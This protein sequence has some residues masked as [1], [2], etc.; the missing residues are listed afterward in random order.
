MTGIT[1]AAVKSLRERTGAGMM[2]CKKALQETGGDEEKA[3]DLLRQK[4][5]AKAAKRSGKE[6]SEGTVFI[7]ANDGRAAMVELLS[8]T[9]FVARSDDFKGFARR[10][11][12]AIA[13]LD[14]PDGEI[15]SGDDLFQGDHVIVPVNQRFVAHVDRND[16]LLKATR[17][18]D[19]PFDLCAV[20]YSIRCEFVI[21]YRFIEP[22]TALVIGKLGAQPDSEK[23]LDRQVVFF[24]QFKRGAR[25]ITRV[26]QPD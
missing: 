2:D 1:A 16:N 18:F 3:I 8:E 22:R 26:V 7:T 4:G 9:D 17:K 15:L 6:T 11:A 24:D 13:D 14:L 19:T 23:Y 20:L 25:I 10:A 21:R 5:T 12:A